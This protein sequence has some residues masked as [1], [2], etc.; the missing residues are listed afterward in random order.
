MD[1]TGQYILRYTVVIPPQW[2]RNLALT[3]TIY[4]SLLDIGYFT[5]GVYQSRMYT[6]IRTDG[7][8]SGLTEGNMVLAIF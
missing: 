5:F 7:R 4:S 8:I 1:L 2:H 6:K 3:S